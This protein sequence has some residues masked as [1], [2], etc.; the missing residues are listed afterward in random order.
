MTIYL[1][2]VVY[3][4]VT[5][6][7]GDLPGVT[8]VIPMQ[9]LQTQVQ[10]MMLQK[11]TKI[12]GRQTLTQTQHSV[13]QQV[14]S[15]VETVRWTA[16]LPYFFGLI[17]SYSDNLVWLAIGIVLPILAYHRINAYRTRLHIYYEILSYT[18]YSPRLPSHVMRACNLETGKF[19]RYVQTL[20]EKG[21]VDEIPQDGGKLYRTSRKGLDLIRDEKLAQFVRELP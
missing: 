13:V 2:T 14:S 20:K 16:T 6:F 15:T 10:T 1:T 4:Q 12:E 11:T 3:P 19:V 21:F 5:G 7:F 17:R 9:V 18:A 8:I